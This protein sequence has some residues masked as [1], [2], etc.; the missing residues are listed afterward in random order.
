[1]DI[2]G[3]LSV[4][5]QVLD[6][7]K[8]LRDIDVKVNDAEFKLRIS[9]LVGH[10]LTLREALMDAQLR[11]SDLRKTIADLQIKLN[12][13]ASHRDTNGLLYEIDTEGKSVGEPYCNLC[14]VREDKLYRLT[15]VAYI[16]GTNG[17][18]PMPPE[19]EHYYCRNC[20]Q[21]AGA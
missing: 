10:I 13:R 3:A 14:F 1:M 15:F 19:R 11:E 7:S 2:I 8:D 5:K 21:R 4:A 18:F 6:I 20:K 16:P 9:D 12:Q 17:Y